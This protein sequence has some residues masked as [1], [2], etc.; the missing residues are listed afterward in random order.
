[1]RLSAY[2]GI[3]VRVITRVAA[4]VKGLRGRLRCLIFLSQPSFLLELL[5]VGG[6]VFSRSA[7]ILG[8]TLISDKVIPPNLESRFYLHLSDSLPR[9]WGFPTCLSASIP[10]LPSPPPPGRFNSIDSFTFDHHWSSLI[11]CVQKK[12]LVLFYIL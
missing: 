12:E 7:V 4:K 3:V 10:H 2:M 6:P 9:G 5:S 1:M 8:E 11:Y